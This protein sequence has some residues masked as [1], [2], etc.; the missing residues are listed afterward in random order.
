MGEKSNKAK[1]DAFEMLTNKVLEKHFKIKFNRHTAIRNIK[2]EYDLV[3]TDGSIIVECKNYT[4]TASG[5]TPSAKISTL[6]EALFWL[7]VAPK[8]S[9]KILCM[10]HSTCSEK[11]KSLAEYFVD[12]S[13]LLPYTDVSVYEINESGKAKKLYPKEGSTANE[14]K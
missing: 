1:G 9:R 4:W 6:H 13:T 8:K 11:P 10:S 3:S 12:S 14:K 2:H 5:A 7:Y